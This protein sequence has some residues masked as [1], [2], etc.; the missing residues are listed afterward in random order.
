[1]KKGKEEVDL[2]PQHMKKWGTDGSLIQTFWCFLHTY[3]LRTGY[4]LV[5]MRSSKG[6]MLN[7]VE[8]TKTAPLLQ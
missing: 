1:M 4:P 2:L 8:P 3:A 5:L 7:K 6:C